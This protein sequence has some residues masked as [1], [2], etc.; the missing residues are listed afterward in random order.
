MDSGQRQDIYSIGDT[1][2]LQMSDVMFCSRLL[3][4]SGANILIANNR[5]SYICSYVNES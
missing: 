5:L 3:N 2:Q 1:P 4:A